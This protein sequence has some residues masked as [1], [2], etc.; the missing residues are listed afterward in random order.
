MGISILHL[1]HSLSGGGAER[2]LS[3]L[4]RE[5]IHL[6]CDVHVAFLEEGPVASAFFGRGICLHK[7]NHR[8]NYDPRI[9]IQIFR[10]ITRI[11]PDIIHTWMLQMDIAGGIASYLAKTPHV[12]REPFIGRFPSANWKNITREWLVR[13]NEAV[14]V[15]NSNGGDGYWAVKCPR[16]DRCIIPNALNLDEI[17]EA[18]PILAKEINLPPGARFILYAG[19]LDT[20]QKNLEN[21][22]KAFSMVC[23]RHDV[24]AVICGEG[25][26]RSR[27]NSA[28]SDNGLAKRILLKGFVQ[29]IW[30][31]MKAADMFVFVSHFE[32]RPNSVLEAMACGCPL[33][34]SDIPAHREFLDKDT[35]LFVNP[36][37]PAEIAEGINTI[38]MSP[39]EAKAKAMR[40]K[41]KA[42]QWSIQKM[43]QEYTQVYM[44][45]LNEHK[46]Q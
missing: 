2:Q 15:S 10:L 17:R 40:A 19:R 31:Y 46:R 28:I 23:R 43:A 25:P 3:Y 30:S 1:I 9:L 22:F 42:S 36:Q 29:N 4:A 32:G 8:G 34:A 21:L 24:Y 39:T 20:Y 18:N 44:N 6:G 38:L 12:L 33:V 13:M 35:A 45:I 5:L 37:D 41:E 26:Y 14:I 11:R 27:L 7:L 16:L